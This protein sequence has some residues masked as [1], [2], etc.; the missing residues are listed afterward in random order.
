MTE[1]PLFK[2]VG[3][4]LYHAFAMEVRGVSIKGGTA[5]VIEDLM[6]RRYGRP[7][8]VES[9]RSVNLAGLTWLD[10]V[11]QCARIREAVEG[12]QNPA[13]L[14]AVER[15]CILARFGFQA[16]RARGIIGLRDHLW[17]LCNTRSGD[18]IGALVY[19]IYQPL[20]GGKGRR[21]RRGADPEDPN[22]HSLRKIER[23]YGVAKST[24]QRDQQLMRRIIHE[25]E[26]RAQGRLEAYFV[27]AKLLADPNDV[28]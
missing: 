10:F 19:A 12:R 16:T 18:A 3:Q 7:Q 9:E 22:E 20:K 15:F 8:R 5:I 14:S 23:D 11:A 4:L 13:D 28:S 24:L 17:S 27:R 25:H 2:D 1:E 26:T 21:R 6:E